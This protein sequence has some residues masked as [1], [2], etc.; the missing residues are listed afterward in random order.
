MKMKT[1]NFD[2]KEIQDFVF[3]LVM[4]AGQKTCGIAHSKEV[5]KM[6]DWE[7]REELMDCL[8]ADDDEYDSMDLMLALGY[9]EAIMDEAEI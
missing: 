3:Q 8:E 7:K 4:K 5:N 6:E 9:S 2:M 1:I